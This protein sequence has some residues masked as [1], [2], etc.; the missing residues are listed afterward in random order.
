VLHYKFKNHHNNTPDLFLKTSQ[1][2]KTGI[3]NKYLKVVYWP[4][5]KI[6]DKVQWIQNKIP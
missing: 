2:N 4:N 3:L 1:A 6:Y 5:K